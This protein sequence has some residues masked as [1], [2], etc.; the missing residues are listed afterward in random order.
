MLPETTARRLAFVRYLY[1]VAV[2]QSRYPEPL[3]GTSILTFHDSI[4]LF[5]QLA[6][7]YLNVGKEN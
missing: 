4:E 2:Q 6:S 7:E 1:G 5:L 3:Y